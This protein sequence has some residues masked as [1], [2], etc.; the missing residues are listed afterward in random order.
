M[1]LVSLARSSPSACRSFTPNKREAVR[2][3]SDTRQNQL[4]RLDPDSGR[5]VWKRLRKSLKKE[6]EITSEH[7]RLP[8]RSTCFRSRVSWVR[9]P[10]AQLL[11]KPGRSSVAEHRKVSGHTFVDRVLF[12]RTASQPTTEHIRLPEWSTWQLTETSC[13]FKSRPVRC[14]LKR[15][16]S[17]HQHLV[18]CLKQIVG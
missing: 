10:P 8:I 15:T 12:F 4:V 1:T 6:T 3:S 2:K 7:D 9:V 16:G 5:A 11:S 18:E 13:W 14:F 17:L